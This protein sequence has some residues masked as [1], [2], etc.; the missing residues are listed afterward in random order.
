MVADDV[1]GDKDRAVGFELVLGKRS[2]HQKVSGS[3]FLPMH[4]QPSVRVF[5]RIGK[6]NCWL[7]YMY[8]QLK[9]PTCRG[10]TRHLLHGSIQATDSISQQ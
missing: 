3:G 4:T 8:G 2:R 5:G 10:D 6:E 9:P 1:G 7:L